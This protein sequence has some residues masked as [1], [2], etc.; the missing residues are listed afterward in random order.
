MRRGL[1]IGLLA[2]LILTACGGTAQ[3]TGATAAAGTTAGNDAGAA[4]APAGGGPYDTG[5]AAPAE[6]AHQKTDATGQ[7]AGAAP[8]AQAPRERLVIRTATLQLLVENVVDAE[9][10]VRRVADTRGGFVLSSQSSGEDSQRQATVSFKVP[11]NRFDEAITELGKLAL[12]VD[13]LDVRGEDVTD[14]Y[15]D[16]ESR[17]RNLRA[18]EARLQQFL[19]EAK[20]I[21]E[22]LQINQ[23]LGEIQGQIERAQGRI[24]YLK[25]SAALST[26]TVSLYS[27]PVIEIVPQEG[28][29]PVSTARAAAKT[30]IV[31]GQGL[32]DISIV[33]AVWS[34]LWVPLL[35]A[36]TWLR[37]R[38]GRPTPPAQA[39]QT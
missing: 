24:T 15:V 3:S 25:Q 12:K 14:E 21:E 7:Q 29:S 34:P 38:L 30:L 10:L 4:P 13:S 11:A 39:P 19:S 8:N 2:L 26:I 20:R 36:A 31:F 37:R 33:F 1:I 22:L 16:L 23:Q 6:E 27:K 17:L 28:W 18:V 35:L 32:A 5:G 9:A